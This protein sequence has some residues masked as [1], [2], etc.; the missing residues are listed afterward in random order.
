MHP[1]G[2]WLTRPYTWHTVGVARKGVL[3]NRISELMRSF[4]RSDWF[5]EPSL[6]NVSAADKSRAGYSQFN[7]SVMQKTPEPQGEDAK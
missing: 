4:E 2:R 7:L 6:S 3:N 5:S 1:F